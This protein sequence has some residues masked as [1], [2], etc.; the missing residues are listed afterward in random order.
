MKDSKLAR[1]DKPD[2]LGGLAR[3]IVELEDLHENFYRG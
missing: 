3:G 2:P 1:M